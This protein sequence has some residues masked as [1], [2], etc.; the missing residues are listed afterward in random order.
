MEKALIAA[1]NGNAQAV[2]AW[3]DEGSGVD[4]RC[5]ERN[6]KTLLIMA[7]YARSAERMQLSVCVCPYVLPRAGAAVGAAAHGLNSLPWL[8]LF[9]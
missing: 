5:A 9:M 7:A 6:G 1:A 2:A 8:E 3:L 4:V